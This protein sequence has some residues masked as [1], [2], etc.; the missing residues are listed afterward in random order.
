MLIGMIVLIGSLTASPA[1]A[2]PFAGKCH[3]WMENGCSGYEA[4]LPRNPFGLLA[5]NDA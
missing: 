5:Y 2:R 4:R 3:L 1:S